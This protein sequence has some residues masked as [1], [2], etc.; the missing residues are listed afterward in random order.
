MEN[1]GLAKSTAKPHPWVNLLRLFEQS[2]CNWPSKRWKN[3]TSPSFFAQ[4]LCAP[5]K[6][7]SLS[8]HSEDS[9]KTAAAA[10]RLTGTILRKSYMYVVNW[11]QRTWVA[12]FFCCTR[13]A[14]QD[15]PPF[16]GP[17]TNPI[18][19]SCCARSFSANASR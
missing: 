6:L 2:S 19:A 8:L 16:F 9:R 3:Y 14:F 13:R 12:Y 15:F 18:K 5:V 7:C 11:Q 1:L 10:T 4:V 17:V